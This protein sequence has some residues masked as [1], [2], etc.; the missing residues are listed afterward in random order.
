MIDM[1]L[2]TMQQWNQW[3]FWYGDDDDDDNRNGSGGWQCKD[4]NGDNN[5]DGL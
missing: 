3:I 5:I 4:D 1:I 2:K